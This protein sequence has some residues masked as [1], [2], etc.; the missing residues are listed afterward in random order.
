MMKISEHEF[1][2]AVTEALASV[3]QRFKDVLQNIAITV[4]DEPTPDQ[5]RTMTHG[6]GETARPVPGHPHHPARHGVRRCD[7]RCHHDLPR[8]ARAR[9]F[10]AP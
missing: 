8:A 4:A 1:E 7:A 5:L 10:H 2:Q 9:M 6:H 3:P